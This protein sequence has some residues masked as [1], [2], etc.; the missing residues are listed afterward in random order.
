MPDM[1]WI[2]DEDSK[3]TDT[4]SV[5][6]RIGVRSFRQ[7]HV[8]EL[9][10]VNWKFE[11]KDKSKFLLIKVT[12][13]KA[14]FDKFDNGRALKLKFKEADGGFVSDADLSRYIKNTTYKTKEEFE[15]KGLQ[16]RIDVMDLDA[17]IDLSTIMKTQVCDAPKTWH[18]DVT[19]IAPPLGEIGEIK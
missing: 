5:I 3:P 15:E 2:W 1:H 8:Q 14:Q 17:N 13:S 19:T 9:Y 10:P 12:L 16:P 6:V 18:D 4:R 11:W 7:G